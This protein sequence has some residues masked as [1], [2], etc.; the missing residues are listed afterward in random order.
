MSFPLTTPFVK[1]FVCL[2]ALTVTAATAAPHLALHAA[3]EATTLSCDSVFAHIDS[4]LY[5]IGKETL[6]RFVHVAEVGRVAPAGYDVELRYPE[7]KP[8][9]SKELRAVRELQR[10][11]V[12][13]ADETID[14]DPTMLTPCP[15]P[16]CGLNL[17]ATLSVS[18]M[19]GYLNVEFCP[20]VRH[21]GQWKRLLSCQISVTPKVTDAQATHAAALSTDRWAEHSVLATGKWAK[22]R[23]SEEGIYQLTAEDLRKM[24]F[25]TPD[26]VHI[27]G[28]G[29]LLQDE[30]FDFSTPENHKL[31]TA[32]PDDLVEVPAMTT[33]DGRLLFWAEGVTRYNW[34]AST[35]RYSHTQNHYS[36]HSYYFITENDSPRA[37]VATYEPNGQDLNYDTSRMA[38][39]KTVPYVSVLDTDAYSWYSGGRRMFD[40][41][42]FSMGSTHSYRLATPGLNAEGSG[43]KTVEVSFG[44]SSSLSSTGLKVT[45]NGQQTGSLTVAKY[46]S[47]TNDVAQVQLGTFSNINGLSGTESNVFQLQTNNSNK[48]R[49]DFIRVNYPRDLVASHTPY[50][51][52]VHTTSP[53]NLIIDGATSHT[54]LWMLGQKGSPTVE[55]TGTVADGKLTATAW[56][57]ERRYT[58]FNDDATFA[59]P[60][61]VGA[62][63]NQDLH[64]HEGIDYIIIIPAN[65]V[66][67]EQA[68]RLGR[69][70]AEHEG[71][72]YC[73]VRADQLYNEFSSGTPDANAYR[74]YLKMLYD[75]AG[76]DT[77]T[78]P[79]YCLFMGKSP[80]DNRLLSTEWRDGSQDDYLLA[81][82]ADYSTKG[83]GSVNSYVTDDFFGMLDDTEG[84]SIRAEKL[85]LSLGRMVCIT[86][87]DAERLI[88][89]VEDYIANDHAGAWQNTIVMLGDDG[90]NNEHMNDAERVVT[91][92]S[93]KAPDLNVQKVY[94]DR[95]NWVSSATGY[96]YPQATQRIHQLMTEGALMFNYSGHG[97]PTTISHQKVLQMNDFRE[98]HSPI[99]PLWVLASCEIYPFDSH[100]NN[101]AEAS[102][103][104]AGGGSIAFMCATRSVFATQNNEINRAFSQQVL[105][106]NPE[107]GA[108]NTMGDALRLAKIGLVESGTDNSINKLKYVFFGDPA[109]RLAMPMGKV[110]LDSING[111]ALSEM[112]QLAVLPAGSLATFSGHVCLSDT[113]EVDPDFDG[114]VTV[115]LFDR[116]ETIVCKENKATVKGNPMVFTER[117]KTI[118]RGQTQ[119]EGGKFCFTVTIPRDISYSNEAGR[120]SLYAISKDRK[121]TYKGTSETFCLNGTAE[122][123]EPDVTPPT[124]VL[125]INSI[126]NPDYTITD[127]NPI[128]IA[129]ISDDWGINSAGIA[130]GHDIELVMDGNAADYTVLN[131]YFNYDFGSHLKGQ[132]VYPMTGLTSGQHTAQLRVWDVNNNVTVS[133]VHFIVR[134]SSASPDQRDGYITATKNPATTDT[135]FIAYFPANAEAEGLVTY[136]VY[137]TRGR[138]V[139]REPVA[140][141]AGATSATHGWDL[142]GQDHGALPGGVYFYRAIVQTKTGAK[143]LDAQKLI[144][145]R[146]D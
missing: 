138:C 122:M 69:L 6:P 92:I 125:Y 22:V 111:K 64:A 38:Q 70:H 10:Q 99:L 31:V 35:R 139:Y 123:D 71:M 25:E 137:D 142:C 119:A 97:S 11:G 85:D 77:Q 65:G 14:A 44:A 76:G 83:I 141:P 61:Y 120:A 60:E 133:D 57:P 140:I 143:T 96:T 32:A 2:S 51:F 110:V 16:V 132:L 124:V 144:I 27:Y 4:S 18:R 13:A 56:S 86:A 45:A 84:A 53:A 88:D 102:L 8:L 26:R 104:A 43:A 95:Y 81:Y 59:T 17:T 7:L 75:R 115:S 33:A 74:R 47:A 63:E 42:D 80:W 79:K 62:V 128:L 28:Y 93:Q 105:S 90:D 72:T 21:E 5:T 127:E 68:E 103:F 109:L 39:V 101:L 34:N 12:V 134:P 40:D 19:Q 121:T 114:I 20:I 24:G 91:V 146:Q 48:A 37:G 112:T 98:V 1:G 106:M 36:T 46:E 52:S 66:L 58:F 94:W 135:R 118:F 23:V 29:G 116:E 54:H 82:E 73:V 130:L 15:S 9:S 136:E 87:E 89:K 113:E 67:A 3:K 49:L 50:S 131:G 30:R 145:L 55:M 117:A 129:D 126:D 108:P 78:M 41:Y 100:E 107:T